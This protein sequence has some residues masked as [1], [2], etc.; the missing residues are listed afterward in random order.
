MIQE[1]GAKVWLPPTL[2]LLL[3]AAG[4]VLRDFRQAYS[5]TVRKRL[6][7]PPVPPA[8]AVLPAFHAVTAC[9]SLS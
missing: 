6:S 9:E 4:R 5:V 3:P 8:E 2:M 7:R 1:L